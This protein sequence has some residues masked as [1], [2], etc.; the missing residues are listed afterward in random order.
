MSDSYR[1]VQVPEL[2]FPTEDANLVM[3]TNQTEAYY[4]LTDLVIIKFLADY[5]TR[6]L[7]RLKSGERG[8]E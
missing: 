2:C 5:Q 3:C 8:E 1:S 4:K 7:M 6:I